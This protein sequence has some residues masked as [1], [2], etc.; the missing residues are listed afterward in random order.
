MFRTKYERVR[1]FTCPGNEVEIEY[2]LQVNDRGIKVPVE[3][4]KINVRDEINSYRDSVDLQILL[5]RYMNGE[6]DVLNRRAASYFD[7]TD[8]PN[9][10][11]E[12]YK[13]AE[14]GK[15]MFEKFSPE[16]KEKFN[17]DYGQFLDQ[18]GTKKFYDIFAPAAPEAPAHES[19]VGNEQKSE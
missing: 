19:E 8:M 16:I 6:K 18:I 14:N 15:S 10:L 2:E 13:M 12:A 9:S 7:A 17:N 3:V 11:A 1:V 5:Q 4:G